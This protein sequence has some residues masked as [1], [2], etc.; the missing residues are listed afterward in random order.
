MNAFC[1]DC[2]S[3]ILV[4]VIVTYI[5]SYSNFTRL[6]DEYSA[7]CCEG[8]FTVYGYQDYSSF[9][10]IQKEIDLP[11]D[12][13]EMLKTIGNTLAHIIK[14]IIESFITDKMLH[15]LYRML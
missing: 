5:L 7:H 1:I 4:D 13:I 14:T 12:D 11:D 3:N 9:L 10:N 8:R 15:I 6:I 2:K